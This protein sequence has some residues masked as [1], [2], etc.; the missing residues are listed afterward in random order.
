MT[1]EA[2][3]IG[4]GA[5]GHAVRLARLVLEEKRRWIEEGPYHRG[6]S[7]VV[8]AV[9]RNPARGGDQPQGKLP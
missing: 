8:Q 1:L 5:H 3:C 9:G 2:L 7:A 6:E 4:T